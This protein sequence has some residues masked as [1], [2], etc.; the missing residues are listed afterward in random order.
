MFPLLNSLCTQFHE[1]CI[2]KRK[3]FTRCALTTGR[4]VEHGKQLFCPGQIQWGTRK[5]DSESARARTLA[6]MYEAGE[7]MR[8]ACPP[9]CFG[10]RTACCRRCT[11]TH[12]CRWLGGQDGFDT[13]GFR[14][15]GGGMNERES[16]GSHE[17]KA[18]ESYDAYVRPHTV[19]RARAHDALGLEVARVCV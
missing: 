14:G 2:T 4:Y 16:A 7:R 11:H 18:Q 15:G 1:G 3:S 6:R 5:V 10:R 19:L 12:L 13:Q 9:R 8:W 17:R